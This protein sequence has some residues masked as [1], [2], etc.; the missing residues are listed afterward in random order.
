MSEIVRYWRG[1]TNKKHQGSIQHA[2]PIWKNQ[3]QERQSTLSHG[4][5]SE[6]GWLKAAKI[7][8]SLEVD[9]RTFR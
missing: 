9:E 1:S 8:K 3:N 4:K 2:E 6:K 5:N 7:K